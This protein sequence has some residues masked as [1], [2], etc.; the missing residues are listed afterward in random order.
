MVSPA[1]HVRD[2]VLTVP[3][4]V[5]LPPSCRDLD[6]NTGLLTL[7]FDEAVSANLEL[8]G[9]TLFVSGRRCFVR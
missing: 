9:I 6:L 1:W 3:D 7:E 8:S 2:I 5:L 4:L